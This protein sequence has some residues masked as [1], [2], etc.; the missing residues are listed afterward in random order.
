MPQA[1]TLALLLAFLAVLGA[2]AVWAAV[3]PLPS[4][5]RE[6][7]CTVTKGSAARLA[8]G[9]AA[10]P[11]RV[12]LTVGVRDILVLRND[13]DVA[14][15]FGPVKLEPGQTHRVPFDTPGEFQLAC[16]LHP[17]GRVD[18][19][20]VPTPRPGWARVAWRVAEAFNP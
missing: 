19:A 5:P 1:V 18:I 10:I 13:D 20:V 8:R 16:S 12:R 11:G 15:S 14:A 9:A 7:L 6:V 17:A 2:A 4:G 3:A